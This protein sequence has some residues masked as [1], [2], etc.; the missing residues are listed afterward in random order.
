[1]FMSC[2]CFF[3]KRHSSFL[4]PFV[5]PCHTACGILVPWPETEPTSPALQD[6]FLTTGPPGTSHGGCFKYW[7]VFLLVGEWRCVS[8]NS[9]CILWQGEEH[10]GTVLILMKKREIRATSFMHL[11]SLGNLEERAVP[12]TV[13]ILWLSSIPS[14][15]TALGF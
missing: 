2:C 4:M 5:V 12:R 10:L 9:Q 7:H 3:A 13:W 1:M 15:R 14:L 6:G 11:H 8:S